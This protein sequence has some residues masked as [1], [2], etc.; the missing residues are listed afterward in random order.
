MSARDCTE[1][2]VSAMIRARLLHGMLCAAANFSR[3]SL[4]AAACGWHCVGGVA[5]SQYSVHLAAAALQRHLH[6]LPRSK[7]LCAYS[8][9]F[10]S[11]GG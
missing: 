5:A 1:Q 4:L 6:I 3:R 10:L 7:Q 2:G 9:H 11:A 8:A